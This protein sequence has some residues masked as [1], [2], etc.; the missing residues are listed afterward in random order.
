MTT[1]TL[2]QVY[3]GPKWLPDTDAHAWD[4]SWTFD[5]AY[6]VPTAIGTLGANVAVDATSIH[7]HTAYMPIG[8]FWLQP[9]PANAQTGQGWEYIDHY[10][11]SGVYPELTMTDAEREP[12]AT[13][14]HNGVHTSGDYVRLW[15]PLNANDGKL[16][17]VEEMDPALASAAWIA[18][19][20]GVLAPH[21]LLRTHHAVLILTNNDGL[22]GGAWTPFLLGWIESF[23]IEDDYQQYAKWSLR[24]TSI[25][26]ILNGQRCPT[27]RIGELDLAQAGRVIQSAQILA[28]PSKERNSGD[29]VAAAPDLTGAAL[30]DGDD[31]TPCIFERTGAFTLGGGAR[32]YHEEEHLFGGSYIGQ[33]N[34]SMAPGIGK[35]YRWLQI[36]KV[37][38][39]DT[40]WDTYLCQSDPDANE[41]I[42]LEGTYDTN[43]RIIICENLNK[44][45]AMFPL[46]EP[47]R[48]KEIGSVWFDGLN[49]N[50]LEGECIGLMHM[51]QGWT[52]PQWLGNPIAFGAAPPESAGL[53]RGSTRYIANQW[54][55]ADGAT[56]YGFAT[57]TNGKIAIMDWQGAYHRGDEHF[58]LVDWDTCAY[59]TDIAPWVLIQLPGMGLRLAADLAIG[60]AWGRVAISDGATNSTNGLDASGTLQIGGEQI[61][62]SS[63]NATGVW[64]TARGVNSTTAAA[65]LADDPVYIINDG[66]ATDAYPVDH[67][68]WTRPAG[69]NSPRDF[70]MRMSNMLTLPRMPNRDDNSEYALDYNWNYGVADYLANT[71]T[72]D[73]A[74]FNV[75]PTWLLLQI[76]EMQTWPAR[77]RI[78]TILGIL[79]TTCWDDEEWLPVG[80]DIGAAYTHLLTMVGIPAACIHDYITNNDDFRLITG[81]KSA[82]AV[83]VDIAD[84][85]NT[86]IKV[87]HMSHIY[88]YD[89]NLWQTSYTGPGS[90]TDP[91][92]TYDR[93][94]AKNVKLL[95]ERPG[96]VGQL[97][98]TW[99]RTDGDD[100]G[101]IVYPDP[102]DPTGMVQTIK[103]AIHASSAY[104]SASLQRRYLVLK[105]PNSI[106]VELATGNPALRT[107]ACYGLD[108]TFHDASSATRVGYCQSID[109]VLENFTWTTALRLIGLRAANY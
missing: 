9:N 44:F 104:A 40:I 66:Q 43:S 76:S 19:L 37:A 86:I 69:K 14:E 31:S 35:G 39:G 34:L 1:P 29:F 23:Q 79:D 58:K 62:Y 87:D 80:T 77:P 74:T 105:Y 18:D 89:N 82:W 5:Y 65:H 100:G 92:A 78:N 3:I 54:G 81:E 33:M 38:G 97:K 8:G 70:I 11:R 56:R 52:D 22:V 10:T 63:K 21:G 36:Y 47:T 84:Y 55:H 91:I 27:V 20:T 64:M 88:L 45:M 83:L 15:A 95:Q 30:I 51:S 94:T 53:Q 6:A 93:A 46:A 12:A 60:T 7:I 17:I 28:H 61:S 48:I 42:E 72:W 108:W 107:G 99:V 98:L 57:P 2:F 32:D 75:R 13:R 103:P 59:N 68:G 102:A 71:W 25:A 85:T 50:P 67:V 16:H 73:L 26:G 90:M 49:M 101:T 24:I 41:W 4:Y 96:A 109:H 106:G